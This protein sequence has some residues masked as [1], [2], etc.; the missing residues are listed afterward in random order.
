MRLAIR[1]IPVVISEQQAE[2]WCPI[3]LNE[4]TTVPLVCTFLID[5]HQGRMRYTLT[6]RVY[7][8]VEADGVFR[9]ADHLEQVPDWADTLIVDV[10][11]DLQAWAAWNSEVAGPLD[12]YDPI[13]A[14]PLN[15]VR[16]EGAI[17]GRVELPAT[18][19]ALPALGPDATLGLRVVDREA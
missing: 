6:L 14:S 9:F 3:Q 15:L 5:S 8:L 7:K 4:R 19:R 11:A 17:Y 12:A 1:G 10:G 18:A 2:H 13:S 16:T